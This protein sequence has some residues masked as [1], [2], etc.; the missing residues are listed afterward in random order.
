MI[1]QIE[2]VSSD[3]DIG[4]PCSNPAVPRV[5]TAERPFVPTVAY[6]VVA[7]HPGSL[8]STLRTTSAKPRIGHG[9]VSEWGSY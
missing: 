2:F 6:G 9:L 5:P 8:N 4:T 3:S 7:N 1:C